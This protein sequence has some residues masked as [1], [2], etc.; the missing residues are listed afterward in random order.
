MAGYT[1]QPPITPGNLSYIAGESQR[2]ADADRGEGGQRTGEDHFA[3]TTGKI[4]K[5]CGQTIEAEQAAR[6]R[7]ETEWAHDVCPVTTD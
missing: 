5:A 3:H 1:P 2:V 6:R 4:C 7:G